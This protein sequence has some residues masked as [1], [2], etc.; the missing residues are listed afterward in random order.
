MYFV[1]V[2][3]AMTHQ[4]SGE[5]QHGNFV[6]VTNPGGRIRIDVLHIDSERAAFVGQAFL[7]ARQFHQHLLA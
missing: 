3:T 5:Q 6:A 4:F 1:R 7:Q 2:Q